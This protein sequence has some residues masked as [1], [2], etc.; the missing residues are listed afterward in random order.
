[1]SLNKFTSPEIGA[2]LGLEVGC[3]NLVCETVQCQSHSVGEIDTNKIKM[4]TTDN[5]EIDIE[6]QNVGLPGHVLHTDGQDPAN[7]YWGPDVG[8]AN[9]IAYAGAGTEI[10]RHLKSNSAD[11]LTADNS[12]IIEDIGAG[13]LDV[14]LRVVNC[15]DPVDAQDLTTKT[16][17]DENAVIVENRKQFSTGLLSGGVISINVDTTKFDV[18]AGTGIQVDPTTGAETPVSWLAQTAIP[19]I[20]GQKNT[21]ISIDFLGNVQKYNQPLPP[22]LQRQEIYLGDAHTPDGINIESVDNQPNVVLNGVNSLFDLGNSLNHLNLSGND[23]SYLSGLSIQKSQGTAFGLGVNFEN[24]NENPN[25]I[26]LPSLNS[27][28][29]GLR[30]YMKNCT[31]SGSLTT[32]NP[33]GLDTGGNYPGSSITNGYWTV[34]RVYSSCSSENRLNLMLGQFEYAS[35]EDAINSINSEGFDDTTCAVINKDCLIGLIVVQKGTIDLNPLIGAEFLPVDKYGYS[36]KIDL[37]QIKTDIQTNATDNTGTVTVHS[38]V[39]SAGSGQIITSLER[40]AIGNNTTAIT[41]KVSKAGDTMTGNLNLTGSAVYQQDS[42]NA[43]LALVR[44]TSNLC[45]EGSGGNITVGAQRNKCFGD[46]NFSQLTTGNDNFALGEA[47][48]D[49]ITTQILNIGIGNYA[50]QNQIGTYNIAIGQYALAGYGATPTAN[51]HNIGI[52]VSSLQ[53]L[54]GG[55]SNIAIGGNSLQNISN[56]GRNVGIGR[57]AGD[58]I[59]SGSRN[60]FVGHQ[61]DAPA[62]TSDS[63][64]LGSNGVA[65]ANN[66]CVIHNVTEIVSGADNSCSLGSATRRMNNLYL[67][68]LINGLGVIGNLFTQTATSATHS[69][70]TTPTSILSTGVG[71]LSIPANSLVAG[72]SLRFKLGGIMTCGNNNDLTFTFLGYTTPNIACDGVTTNGSYELECEIV[73]RGVGVTASMAINWNFAYY[74]NGGSLAG[75]A[76]DNPVTTIDTTAVNVFDIVCVLVNSGMSINSTMLILD[77]SR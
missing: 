77:K 47:I 64:V 36:T 7:V 43:R 27:I 17:V 59:T 54:V 23:V 18:S 20:G 67:G 8:T 45:T 44:E 71:S 42:L 19:V 70:Q 29:D 15:S 60:V 35:K 1:M 38:D 72:S 40:T 57:Q 55:S 58:S 69:T 46:L 14:G 22:N 24:D 9:G 30:Y 53:N 31:T 51:T 39:S 5:K 76:Y 75:T 28:A 50:Q 12:I 26:D 25:V 56:G 34:Q 10:G 74:N 21:H 48:L 4:Y 73:I 6:F 37:S 65:T 16:Y 52:G 33:N 13:T 66:Q 41:T 68:G 62:T 32:I 63:I 49:K 61:A 2:Q 11:G 3:N